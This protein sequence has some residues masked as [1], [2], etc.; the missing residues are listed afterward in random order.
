MTSYKQRACTTQQEHTTANK[1]KDAKFSLLTT[2]E[3]RKNG[4]G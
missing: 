2:K 3:L 4:E 1:V